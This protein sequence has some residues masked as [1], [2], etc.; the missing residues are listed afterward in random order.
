MVFHLTCLQFRPPIQLQEHS[1]NSERVCLARNLVQTA[2][3]MLKRGPFGVF[4]WGFWP[5]RDLERSNL[6]LKPTQSKS[7]TRRDATS[8]AGA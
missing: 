7:L 4:S 3:H 6:T 8:G 2:S 5:F 1:S